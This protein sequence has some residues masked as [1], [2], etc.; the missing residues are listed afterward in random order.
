MKTSEHGLKLLHGREGKRNTAYLDSVGVWTIG[1]GHTGPDVHPGLVW[2]DE[3]VEA[4]FAKD[5][6]RF[7]K[8]VNEAVKVPL[9]QHAF[10]ALV[11]FAY[12]V[13]PGAFKSSTLVRLLNAGDMAGAA[14]QFDRWHIPAEITS[15]RNGE[16]EQFK[17]TAFEARIHEG[18]TA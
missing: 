2:T 3:Q 12:N 8:A 6:E 1:Y 4:A 11:S 16:R 14:R 15:R 10:D 5:L 9:P 17:G 13:G 18:V 7:E